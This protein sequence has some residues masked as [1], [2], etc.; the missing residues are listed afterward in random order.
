MT[1][2]INGVVK[3]PRYRSGA[4]TG[5]IKLCKSI[6]RPAPQVDLDYLSQKGKSAGRNAVQAIISM[7]RVRSSVIVKLYSHESTVS[8]LAPLR[9][10]WPWR[11]FFPSP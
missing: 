9:H 2:E 5:Y 7:L 1:Q 11:R 8:Y 4:D 10:P 3:H 6:H